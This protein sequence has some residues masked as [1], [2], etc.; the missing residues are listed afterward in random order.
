MTVF[1]AAVVFLHVMDEGGPT[2][3][4]LVASSAVVQGPLDLVF[5]VEVRKVRFEFRAGS[6]S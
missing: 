5:A 3:E 6:M 4:S 2:K 1:D